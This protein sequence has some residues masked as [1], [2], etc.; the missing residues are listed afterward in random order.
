MTNQEGEKIKKI[1]GCEVTKNLVKYVE[2]YLIGQND[3][4]FSDNYMITWTNTQ[5]DLRG[6]SKLKL[7]WLGRISEIEMNVLPKLNFF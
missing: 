6:W 5:S 4:I 3:V 1:L 7:F 2:I